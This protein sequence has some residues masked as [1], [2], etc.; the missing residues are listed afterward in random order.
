MQRMNIYPIENKIDEENTIKQTLQN[1]TKK[2][3]IIRQ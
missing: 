2:A 1:S 3:Y